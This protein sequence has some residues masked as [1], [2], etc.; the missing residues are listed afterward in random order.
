MRDP[1][2]GGAPAGAP[3]SAGGGRAVRPAY[4]PRAAPAVRTVTAA[5]YP[6]R[7]HPET[8]GVVG[9]YVHSYDP[10]QPYQSQIPAMR[11]AQEVPTAQGGQQVQS[12]TPIY[13]AL[14]AEYLRAFRALP[15]DRSGEEDLGFR[16]FGTGMHGGRGGFVGYGG[17]Q[18][19]HPGHTGHMG[20]MGGMGGMGNMGGMGHHQP[21]QHPGHPQH[22]GTW[23]PGFFRQHPGQQHAQAALPPGPRRGA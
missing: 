23:Q 4:V 1:G 2:A 6:A 22:T 17:H 11:P 21:Q 19:V 15:G 14:Y 16:S 10:H 7:P 5:F 8:D 9:T 3:A 12:F 13:D 20:N 18:P